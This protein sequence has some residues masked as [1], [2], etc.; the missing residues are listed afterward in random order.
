MIDEMTGELLPD[1]MVAKETTIP[2]SV[3]GTTYSTFYRSIEAEG[4]EKKGTFLCLHSALTSSYLYK[5]L[6]P[7]LA[8]EGYNAIAPDFLG[9]GE[10]EKPSKAAGGG[11]FDYSPSSFVS[12]LD[13]FVSSQNISGPLFVMTQGYVLGQYGLLYALEKSEQIDKL[14]VLNTPL[15]PQGTAFFLPFPPIY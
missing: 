4:D 14:V 10:S 15:L 9:H 2:L 5:N 11:T 13:A 12:F 3:N 7:S 8:K 1:A 6:L